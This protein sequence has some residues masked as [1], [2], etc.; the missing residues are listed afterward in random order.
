MN[1]R[2]IH[3]YVASATFWRKYY[4][5]YSI[6]IAWPKGLS[7]DQIARRFLKEAKRRFPDP[8]F[9]SKARQRGFDSVQYL[10]PPAY[11]K[12]MTKETN[13]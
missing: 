6:T 7:A 11:G 2:E 5:S 9:P 12:A 10:P 13:T 1:Q 3:Y 4:G 8:V